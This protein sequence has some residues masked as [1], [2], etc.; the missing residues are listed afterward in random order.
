MNATLAATV[1]GLVALVID[2]LR[3]RRLE[4][5]TQQTIDDHEHRLRALERPAN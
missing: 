1:L 5:R 2:Y 3:E 4:E